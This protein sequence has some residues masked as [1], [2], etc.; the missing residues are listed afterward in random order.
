MNERE[1]EREEK[2]EEK[3]GKHTKIPQTTKIKI[4]SF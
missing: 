2:K 4:K 3:K 1:R